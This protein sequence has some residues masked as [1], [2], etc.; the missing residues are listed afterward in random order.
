M[1]TA[2][3]SLTSRPARRSTP[4]LLPSLSGQ[5]WP[6]TDTFHWFQQF[7]GPASTT[8][9]MHLSCSHANQCSLYQSKAF[10]FAACWTFSSGFLDQPLPFDDAGI[11]IRPRQSFRNRSPHNPTLLFF[12]S[13]T[14]AVLTSFKACCHQ[15]HVVV[16]GFVNKGIAARPVVPASTK[17]PH[18]RPSI[19]FEVDNHNI[20]GESD[21]FVRAF[22]SFSTH[23]Y[24]LEMFY[25]PHRVAVVHQRPSGRPLD[26][27]NK[28]PLFHAWRAP[29]PHSTIGPL[30][31][32]ALEAP[33]GFRPLANP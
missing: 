32:V 22:C 24:E 5:E 3:S 29:P 17:E 23:L 30:N 28:P 10:H 4:G 31:L 7:P 11:I 33:V 9:T 13:Y 15:W 16:F 14:A 21:N 19:T 25:R 20:H 26:D 18:H 12:G 6:S 8:S 1:L 2:T 27:V